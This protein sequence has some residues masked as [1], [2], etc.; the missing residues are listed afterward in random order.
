[1]EG[2]G[3]FVFYLNLIYATSYI[4]VY[5]DECVDAGF[6]TLNHSIKNGL[7]V[8]MEQYRGYVQSS[9][10]RDYSVVGATRKTIFRRSCAGSWGAL[11]SIVGLLNFSG[12]WE[13]TSEGWSW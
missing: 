3:S 13:E 5:D 2:G 12:Q 11:L 6:V 8:W 7:G 10:L 4:F 9:Y 1:M